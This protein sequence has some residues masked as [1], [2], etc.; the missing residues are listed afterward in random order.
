MSNKNFNIDKAQELRL[1]YIKKRHYAKKNFIDDLLSYQY[2]F[3][4]LS[5]VGCTLSTTHIYQKRTIKAVCDDLGY[6]LVEFGHYK[7]IDFYGNVLKV[8]TYFKFT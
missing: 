8:D 6:N 5:I 3:G 2:F 4:D 7:M 1:I